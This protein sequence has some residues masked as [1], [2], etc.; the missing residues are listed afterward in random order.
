[1]QRAQPRIGQSDPPGDVPDTAALPAIRDLL[2]YRLRRLAN[3]I[4]RSAALRYRRLFDVSLGEWRTIALLGAAAPLSLN[5]LAKAAGL[6]KGQMSRVVAGLVDRGLIR[7][8][9]DRSDNRGIE[10]TLTRSGQR[11]YDGLI[12]AARLRNDRLLGSLSA[13]ERRLLDQVLRKLEA[14]ARVLIHEEN[15]GAARLLVRNPG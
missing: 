9:S 7:K 12:G 11:V 8:K 6:D 13:D 15:G 4:S 5:A 2:S 14:E 1:M 10:L 3:Q